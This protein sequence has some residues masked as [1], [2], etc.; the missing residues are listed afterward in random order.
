MEYAYTLIIPHYNIPKLLRR[1]LSTVPHRDDMQVI[2]VDDCSTKELDELENVRKDYYWVEW[3]TTG[4]NGGGGKARNI[5]LDHAKGKYLIFADADDY[6]NLCFNDLLDAYR[7]QDFDLLFFSANSVDTETLNNKDGY[8]Y[9][10]KVI[11]QYL[12]SH[13]D[14]EIKYKLNSPWGK[15]ISRKLVKKNG[16]RFTE[17]SVFN[18]MQFSQLCDYFASN[19]TA[20]IRAGYC[21]TIRRDSVSSITTLEKEVK[22]QLITIEHFDFFR[23]NNIAY[24]FEYPVASCFLR[25]RRVSGWKE[26]YKSLKRWHLAGY[27][28]HSIYNALLSHIFK[29]IVRINFTRH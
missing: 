2:V 3:Y 16:I 15:I 8:D 20:D 1:L 17:S 27:H 23:K 24:S 5:G 22:K 28:W 18:D 25:I 21:Y 7:G 6:F 29:H 12:K 26:A 14:K 19:I 4:T 9:Q 10:Y 13:I 11:Y